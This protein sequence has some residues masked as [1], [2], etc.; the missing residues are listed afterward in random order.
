[1]KFVAISRSWPY[2]KIS[3][4]FTITDFTEVGAC[5]TCVPL[6]PAGVFITPALLNRTSSRVS[7]CKKLSTAGLI[8]LKSAKLS[9]M[10]FNIPSAFF[11]RVCFLISSIAHS[12]RDTERAATY[13]VPPAIQRIFASS[14]PTPDAAPVMMK[15]LPRR[16]GRSFSV[17][18]GEGGNM[19][20]NV[21][22]MIEI[23]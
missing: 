23:L 1:M 8:V 3:L 16:D 9:G 6:L 5:L 10:D 13:T 2:S 20:D 21:E 4:A 19:A 22:T 11:P 12:H 17:K 7:C 18:D 14:N 15:T